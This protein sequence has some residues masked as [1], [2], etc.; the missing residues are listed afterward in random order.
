MGKVGRPSLYKP[1]YCQM[2][3]DHMSKGLSYES[4]CAITNTCEDTLREWE[5]VHEEYSA[6]KK[7]AFYLNRL[8]W[9]KKGVDHLGDK[10]FNSTIW[11]FNMKNRFPKQWREKIEVDA[12]QKI[13]AKVEMTDSEKETHTEVMNLAKE[14]IKSK[15]K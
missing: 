9:E 11:I 1:E 15:K 3:I 13:D 6:S 5:K 4:F 10:S 2:L 7:T 8:F 14:Y 12:N